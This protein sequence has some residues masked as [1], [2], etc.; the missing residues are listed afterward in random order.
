[1]AVFGGETVR[2]RFGCLR[3]SAVHVGG[4]EMLVCGSA[5]VFEYSIRDFI[6]AQKVD[7][8]LYGERWVVMGGASVFGLLSFDVN[9]LIYTGGFLFRRSVLLY[10]ESCGWWCL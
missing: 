2:R 9:R 6:E 5:L 7:V 3:T 10:Q 8:A 4:W 1:M